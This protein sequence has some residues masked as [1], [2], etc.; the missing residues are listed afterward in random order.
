M[1][2]LR[3]II[4]IDGFI[5]GIRTVIELDG[6]SIVNG[7][8][9][10]GK[11]STLK[12]L[13]FFYG[14]DPSQLDS[15]SAGRDP[16]AQFYLPRQ[17]SLLIFEYARESGLCCAVAYRNKSGTKHVYRFLEGGFV[18]ERFSQKDTSGKSIYHK[19]H[20]LKTHWKQLDL[21][22][23]QQIE[24]VTDYRAII[25]NDS[26]LINRLA[27][28][29]VLRRMAASYC[30]GSRKTHMRYIDRICA[31]IISRSG[32]M[33]R[34]KDMLA[35]IMSEDGVV[36]PESPIHRSDAS[37]AKEINSLREFEKEIPRLKEVLKRHHERLDVDTVLFSYAGQALHIEGELKTDVAVKEQIIKR[38]IDKLSDLTGEWNSQ[39]EELSTKEIDARNHVNNCEN[40]IKSL[41]QQYSDY[42]DQSMDQK[43][44]DFDNLSLFI[45]RKVE[46]ATRYSALNEDV[47]SEE[48]VL[49][50]ELSS[51]RER[52]EKERQSAQKRLD[53]ERLLA[54]EKE[55]D[56][57]ERRE[58]INTREYD[59]KEQAREQA[60]PEREEL[61]NARAKALA[62]TENG[63]RNDE[64][65]LE[66]KTIENHVEELERKLDELRQ[67][68]IAKEA[69]CLL[70]R[71][72]RDER[73]E[74]L[75]R[76]KRAHFH[77]A[78]E[79]DRLHKLAY[80]EDGTWLKKLRESDP[81]WVMQLGK[82]IDS[83]LLQRK[84][85]DA[86]HVTDEGEA[87]FGWTLN[88]N[89]IDTPQYAESEDQ[90]RHE[91]VTQEVAVQC[92]KEDVAK[93][94][95]ACEKANKA[96]K[97]ADVE[98][99]QAQRVLR[100][101]DSQ[102]NEAQRHYRAQNKIID[103]AI[104]ERRLAAKKEAE[105][106]KELLTDFEK[107]LTDRLQAIKNLYWSETSELQEAWSIEKIRLDE[108][109]S[110][111]ETELEEIGK[112]H[113]SR[114]KEIKE[115]YIK[116]CSDKGIDTDTLETSRNNLEQAREKVRAVTGYASAVNAY[117]EWLKTEWKKRDTLF[118]SLDR[119]RKDHAQIVEEIKDK[120]RQHSAQKKELNTAKTDEE[121]HLRELNEK[122][123][124]ISVLK[125]RLGSYLKMTEASPLSMPF[126]LLLQEIESALN[127][128][129]SLKSKLITDIQSVNSKIDQFGET[130]IAQAWQRAKDNL[131]QELGFDDAYDHKF[132]L[133]LPQAL[134]IFIGEEVNSIKSARIESLRGVGK[135][136]TD[137]FE[138][139]LVV[140]KRIKSQSKKITEAI[141][142][143][144]LIDALSSM[145][146]ELSS[147]VQTIDYWNSLKGFSEAWQEWR[148][149]GEDSLPDQQFID[150][151][152]TLVNALQ[153]IKS[154][155]HLRDYFDLHIR[156]V[157]NGNERIIRND[158]QLDNSTS[159]GLKYLALCVIFIGISRLLCP[160]RDVKLHWPIDELGILHGENISRLFKMLNQGGIVMVGGFPSEDPSMLRHFTHRQVI[161]INKGIRIIDIPQSSLRERAIARHNKEVSSERIN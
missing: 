25:Q 104:A 28:S 121:R 58:L 77:A 51:E 92:A 26:T 100:Q 53:A 31:A 24:V 128:R 33:E 91:Y 4:Q 70:A 16:F 147:K 72:E 97:L 138:K 47:K 34:M 122:S 148:E 68:S 111:F 118:S 154:G 7:T 151:M 89:M 10:A 37:L 38:L 90:L 45:D 116:A 161:D 46:A 125:P 32:N 21:S 115:D 109:C 41:N 30:L 15:H 127:K 140:H 62:Q 69:V 107:L 3:R 88:L 95:K 75:T 99:E 82:V 112:H 143:N 149:S 84:D 48:N 131:R 11:S 141:S 80:A 23:S 102:R 114:L 117:R 19:G 66:L 43:V 44:A 67:Q 81:G 50:R 76:V 124:C 132:L 36:F 96:Y 18:E 5:P 54:Q 20:D 22:C 155:H 29:K 87:L 83:D 39:Y 49:N 105:S 9:G 123:E 40:Q 2:G 8:N 56:Y 86:V 6:H 146:L 27:D 12:L 139:L 35:N 57:N 79:L 13:S 126:D 133:N 64:E 59:A 160:D 42:E 159:D 108:Q 14:G 63:G 150:E 78:E 110:R 65:S 135:G 98:R 73:N 119:F 1:Y 136:L 61:R 94:E 152:S 85:L 17:T 103:E 137:F 134:E 156:M 93:C 55:R 101:G 120:K 145:E 129:E 74:K 142:K 130:Q 144:M 158:N 60:N 106:V 52:Y 113:K 157:E 71:Q 153:S